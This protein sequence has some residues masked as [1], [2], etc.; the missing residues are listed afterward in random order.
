MHRR[1]TTRALAQTVDTSRSALGQ[2]VHCVGQKAMRGLGNCMMSVP[3]E[4][5]TWRGRGGQAALRCEGER[6]R[7]SASFTAAIATRMA[8]A[9]FISSGSCS[10]CATRR[11]VESSAFST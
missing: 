6:A 8:A 9:R 5:V 7:S 2:R 11:A 4:S 10:R 1:R 3:F